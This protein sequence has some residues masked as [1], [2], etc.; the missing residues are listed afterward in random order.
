MH[1]HFDGV[2]AH[3]GIPV[4][5]LFFELAAREHNARTVGKRHKKGILLGGEQYRLAAEKDF[6]GF[7]LDD[8]FASLNRGLAAADGAAQKGT[9]AG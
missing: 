6:A 9:D 2:G 1:V 8:E 4:V 3:G 7:R 5:E